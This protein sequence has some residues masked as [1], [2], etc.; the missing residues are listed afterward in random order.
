MSFFFSFYALFL[1]LRLIKM[2]AM[3]LKDMNEETDCFSRVGLAARMLSLNLQ[4]VV[5]AQMSNVE[6]SAQQGL[7]S[8]PLDIGVSR[9]KG[10]GRCALRDEFDLVM[11]LQTPLQLTW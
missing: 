10:F 5:R 4:L 7:H 3:P 1:F 11:R 9:H 2:Q 6:T 8:N